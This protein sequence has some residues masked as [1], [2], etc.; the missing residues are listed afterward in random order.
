V[1]KGKVLSKKQRSRAIAMA[2][3][4]KD[5]HEIAKDLAS[6]AYRIKEVLSGRYDPVTRLV[7]EDDLAEMRSL[8]ATGLGSGEIG[9][10]LGWHPYTVRRRLKQ[11]AAPEWAPCGARLSLA[12]REEIGIGLAMGHKYCHIAT[13]IGRATSTVTREVKANGGPGHY[14][15][16]KAHDRAYKAARRPKQAKLDRCPAL[17]T[18]VGA[19]LVELWSPQQICGRLRARHGDDPMM[20]VSHETIYKSLY[21]Q[22]RGALRKELS[23]CLRTGRAVRKPRSRTEQ[24]GTIPGKV[25]I[26]ERPAEVSDRA[27]PGHWEGDLIKGANGR[28]CVGTRVERTTRYLL[29]LH[30][31]D[32]RAE[33]VSAAMA[34]AIATLPAKLVKT[35]TWDQG[36]EMARHASFSIASGVQV[37]FCDPHS[38]WQRG[39]NENTNGLLRQYMPKSTDLS[40]FGP[41]DLERIAASLNGRPRETLDF[42]TP[43]EK[44]AELLQ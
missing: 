22:G 20:R 24:R 23:A 28:S 7:D 1:V 9:A 42:M 27:V 3:K 31:A 44:M 14:E 15:A 6:S 38:P 37:Y 36:S 5:I 19:G 21:V 30:L 35:I 18:A 43:S 2:A 32:G 10:R 40:V 4:G 13:R 8:A 26:S 41:A 11:A 33:T 34:A 25:M 39:T 12:E 29:L 17:A 16:W